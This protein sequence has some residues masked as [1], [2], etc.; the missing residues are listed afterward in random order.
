MAIIL[1]NTHGK[2]GERWREWERQGESQAKRKIKRL[3]R[4]LIENFSFWKSCFMHIFVENCLSNHR[5]VLFGPFKNRTEL[6]YE[7]QK[8][9]RDC[10]AW[11]RSKWVSLNASK[12]PL[13]KTKRV[14]F[15][16]DVLQMIPNVCVF[17]YYW[18]HWHATIWLSFK[19]M[20]KIG[21][22]EH[23]HKAK[24]THSQTGMNRL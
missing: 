10:S 1:C 9:E 24:L 21:F 20:C 15:R 7:E 17:F 8:K 5:S 18:R 19:W 22:R 13:M 11:N 3:T 23:T 2:C 14:S 4:E 6:V 12:P 16:S